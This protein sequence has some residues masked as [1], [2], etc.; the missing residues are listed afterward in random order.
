MLLQTFLGPIWL[1][2]QHTQAKTLPEIQRQTHSFVSM[3][4]YTEHLALT[5]VSALE[6]SVVRLLAEQ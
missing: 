5:P 3:Q 1:L 4:E 2:G 6:P